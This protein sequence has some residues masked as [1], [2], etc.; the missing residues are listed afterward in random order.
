MRGDGTSEHV[1]G[2]GASHVLLRWFTFSP[3]LFLGGCLWLCFAAPHPHCVEHVLCS[4]PRSCS[5][6]GC[7][8]AAPPG[9]R[10]SGSRRQRAPEMRVIECKVREPSTLS[11]LH[12]GLCFMH[13]LQNHTNTIAL[14][15]PWCMYEYTY[16]HTRSRT[17]SG[18][19]CK[20]VWS[21][22]THM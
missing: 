17:T 2:A 5:L 15:I 14:K 11:H 9:A 1:W 8:N 7:W 10:N 12:N 16:T 3:Q 13:H 21:R 6:R 19:A 4:C 22:M 20:H 18:H